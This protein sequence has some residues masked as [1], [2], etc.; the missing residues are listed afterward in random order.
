MAGCGE[1]K[2]KAK[3]V[4]SRRAGQKTKGREKPLPK[5]ILTKQIGQACS[6]RYF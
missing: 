5:K 4:K 2:T 6:K 1:N 3:S